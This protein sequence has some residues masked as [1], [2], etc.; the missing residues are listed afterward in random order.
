MNAAK[1]AYASV[2][3]TTLVEGVS[4]HG[5]VS[6]L[7][8]GAIRQI[9]TA[10]NYDGPNRVVVMRQSLDK[11]L[12]IVQELQSSL[13]DP[14]TDEIASNLFSLYSFINGELINAN[15]RSAVEPLAVCEDLLL[16]LQDAWLAIDP[17][18]NDPSI[19]KAA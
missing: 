19:Q 18:A 11:A 16:T 4:A 6:M 2:R 5:L 3:K 9:R 15:R 17:A 10:R 1:Q 13:K 12:A 7:Y 8:D 14:E